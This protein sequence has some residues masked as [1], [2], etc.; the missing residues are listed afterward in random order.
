MHGLHSARNALLQK[1]FRG[2]HQRIGMKAI[3]HYSLVQ[4]IVQ[5]NKIHAL[6]MG[7]VR[8]HRS[9]ALTFL[10]S[11]RCEVECFVKAIAGE[12]TFAFE[13]VKVFH[14]WDWRYV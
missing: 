11:L 1:Q 13:D 14:C 7:H 3:L 9:T 2:A 10:D 6:M 8:T 12:R 4:Q 5:R